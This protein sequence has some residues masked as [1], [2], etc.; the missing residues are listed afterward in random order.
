MATPEQEDVEHRRKPPVKRVRVL[1]VDDSALMRR[2]LTDLL[3]TAPEIEVVGTARDGR[4]AVLQA[5]RLRPDVVTLDVEMPEASGIDALP[6]LL[7]IGGLEVVMVQRA[8]AGRGRCHSARTRARR[9]RLLAQAR[10]EPAFR[11]AS[12]PRPSGRQG[13]GGRVER[14]SKRPQGAPT[15]REG[16]RRR[17][18]LPSRRSEMLLQ[19]RRC[20]ARF[21][22]RRA[23]WWCNVC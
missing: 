12:Q 16:Q 14:A 2:L 17:F 4:D 21:R 22:N 23:R 5:S 3:C 13:A 8:D 18:T 19:P 6:L 9:V 7:G 15:G 20:R 10:E 11:A 1:V